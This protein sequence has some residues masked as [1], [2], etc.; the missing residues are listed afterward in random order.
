MDWFYAFEG[1]QRGPVPD[2]QLDELLRVGTITP[3]TL[4]WRAGMVQWQP[5]HLARPQQVAANQAVCAECNRVFAQDD[6]VLLEQS[7]VCAGCKPIFLQRLAEGAPRP[8]TAHSVWRSPKLLVL[9]RDAELPDRCVRCNGPAH[10]YR[11][12]RKLYWHPPAYYLL[13]LLSI[14]IYAV[15]A[16][17]VRKK[18]TVHIGLCEEHRKG[19]KLAILT[20]CGLGAGAVLSCVIAGVSGNAFW[21]IPGILLLLSALILAAVKTSVISAARIDAEYV[22]LKGAQPAFLNSLPEWGGPP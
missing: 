19:R 17:I 13:I 14:L 11:L 5:L 16:I 21:V 9:R 8:S 4:V 6:M 3:A 20:S 12:K 1:K 2:A 10:G 22:R 7:W 15:V 18:A